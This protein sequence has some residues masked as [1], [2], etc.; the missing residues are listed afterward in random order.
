MHCASCGF[1]NPEGM[2]F[3]DECGAKLVPTCPSCGQE[4]RPTAK[5]CGKCGS[6]IPLQHKI[7][8]EQK[9]P[10][11]KK[12]KHGQAKAPPATVLRSA[13]VGAE[14][15]QL[16]VMFCDLVG[17]T[18]LSEQLDPEELREVVQAYQETCAGVIQQYD[19]HIA[20]Y[21]GDGLLVY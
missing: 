10:T 18:T 3:C 15:R 4:L 16:T 7:S 13:A 6:S 21:L 14:R 9:R 11:A 20:Q 5:F 8:K 2:N 12:G 1:E 17:S 19:G